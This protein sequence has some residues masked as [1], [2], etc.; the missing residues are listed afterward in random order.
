MNITQL[1][2][3]LSIE[4]C[5]GDGDAVVHDIIEDSRQVLGQKG[6]MFVA[7]PGDRF[8]GRSFINAAVEAGAVAV[9][10]DFDAIVPTQI[11]ALR[12]HD[13]PAAAAQVAERIFDYPNRRLALIG[14]T[15]TNGKTTT[16]HLV[17]HILSSNDQKCGLIGTVIVDDGAKR[18]PAALT[19]PSA[20][21]IS[22]L[23]RRMVDNNC[24][25]CVMEVSSHAL[26]QG[27]VDALEFDAA[28]FTN[29]TGDHLDYH[30]TME[31]YA[32]AKAALFA[33]LPEDGAAVV[34]IDDP[35]SRV[36]VQS[37]EGLVHECSIG[38]KKAEYHAI[39]H[40]ATAASS[41][42][43]F[44]LAEDSIDINLPLI[45]RHNVMNALQA[46]A[47]AHGMDIEASEIGIA[48]QSCAAPPG[49]FEPVDSGE[50]DLTILVDYAHTDDALKNALSALRP[51]VPADAKLRVVFGCG[52]DRDRTKRPRMAAV[53][54]QFADDIIITSDNP[55]TEDPQAIVDE[56]AAGVPDEFAG[57]CRTIVDRADAIQDA[58]R[59]AGAGDVILIAGKGH[60]DYQI[61]GETKRSFDDRKIAAAAIASLVEVTA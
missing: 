20:I 23:L 51:L 47:I 44:N 19:T 13:L 33:A 12:A 54:C 2:E 42:V 43:T 60:E 29:L 24:A 49:R 25:A 45:G 46:A 56:V 57:Q 10:T 17:Q 6:V 61:I 37:C 38:N 53:A 18:A 16:A 5:H 36:M 15:G 1:I 4:L 32:Q 41:K 40:S 52:G 8:D 3:G 31:Q 58:I 21:D 50:H 9:L 55:R 34:N 48:L 27:R 35:A 7:R 59:N 26:E 22:R 39:I 30:G 11:A 14:I 28:V